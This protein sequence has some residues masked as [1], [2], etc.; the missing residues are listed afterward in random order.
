MSKQHM[1]M[2]V[3]EGGIQMFTDIIAC[4]IAAAAFATLGVLL[5]N[6]KCL[7]IVT[8]YF[9]AT[10]KQR[11]AYDK[12]ALGRFVGGLMFFFAGCMVL[13]MIGIA[14]KIRWISTVFIVL[15]IVG[16]FAAAIYANTGNRFKRQ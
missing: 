13:L 5:V 16:G 2:H 10:P 11:E 15:V 1:A 12:V 7:M 14:L 4:G 8:A 6:G 9:A 3:E